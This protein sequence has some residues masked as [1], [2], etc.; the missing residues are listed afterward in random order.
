MSNKILFLLLIAYLFVLSEA[1]KRKYYKGVTDR[2]CGLAMGNKCQ[3]KHI[4]ACHQSSCLMNFYRKNATQGEI[5]W[6]VLVVNFDDKTGGSCS[7]SILNERWVLT[8]AHCVVTT[9]TNLMKVYLGTSPNISSDPLYDVKQIKAHQSYETSK[10]L[11]G[12]YDIA[13]LELSKP[14]VFGPDV[15]SVCLPPSMYEHSGKETALFAGYGRYDV[16]LKL[17]TGWVSFNSSHIYD[18]P[19]DYTQKFWARLWS[20]FWSLF[21]YKTQPIGLFICLW[22]TPPDSGYITCSGDSGG[23]LVQFDREG[24]A[25]QIGILLGHYPNVCDPCDRGVPRQEDI[26]KFDMSMVFTRVSM[27]IEWIEEQITGRKNVKS[28]SRKN[29]TRNKDEI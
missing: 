8:A 13:L 20:W 6:A 26:E 27:Y 23:P 4:F 17:Q 11:G 18:N 12:S 9:D 21:G 10:F 24:R 25:V 15:C 19:Y 3:H 29:T 28:T 1:I 7:G 22:R 14:I 16:R 2:G 5:P